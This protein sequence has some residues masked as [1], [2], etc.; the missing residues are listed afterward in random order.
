MGLVSDME[1]VANDLKWALR[2]AFKHLDLAQ[3]DGVSSGV[4]AGAGLAEGF[5]D[6]PG[7]VSSSMLKWRVWSVGRTA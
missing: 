6:S 7:L 4:W 5:I 3:E 2:D 1:Q